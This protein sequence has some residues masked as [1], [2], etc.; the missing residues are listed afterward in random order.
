MVPN[1]ESL[2]F[3]FFCCILSYIIAM[4]SQSEIMGKRID[5]KIEQFLILALN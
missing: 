1:F 4:P 3:L 5:K 2:F